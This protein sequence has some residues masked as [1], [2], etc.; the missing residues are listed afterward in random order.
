M[1]ES[2][3]HGSCDTEIEA[4]LLRQ[5]RERAAKIRRETGFGD[6]SLGIS[7]KKGVAG[8]LVCSSSVS[9]ATDGAGQ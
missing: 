1:T 5:Y 6:I 2:V 4:L 8:R 3:I 7:I 9:F